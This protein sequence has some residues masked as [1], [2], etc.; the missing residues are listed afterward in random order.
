[1][2]ITY[3]LWVEGRTV[4]FQILEQIDLTYCSEYI[5]KTDWQVKS[6]N[7]PAVDVGNKYIFLRGR[8]VERHLEV[9]ELESDSPAEA[10]KLAAVIHETLED[11]A[12]SLDDTP[13]DGSPVNVFIL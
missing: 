2:K 13:E 12:K 5:C 4:K 9:A 3:K 7:F 10:H 1:M 11:W 6:Y 8:Q